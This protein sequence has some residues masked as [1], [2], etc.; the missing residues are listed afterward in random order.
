MSDNDERYTVLNREVG[1]IGQQVET[2]M[3]NCLPHIENEIKSVKRWVMGIF[4]AVT[5]AIIASSLRILGVI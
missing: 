3:K 2:I 1:V 4:S 5:I